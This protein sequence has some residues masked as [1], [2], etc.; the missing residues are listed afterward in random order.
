MS[1]LEQT[2]LNIAETLGEDA[3]SLDT[4]APQWLQ[5]MQEGVLVSLHIGRWRG[6]TRLTWADLG[7]QLDETDDK[8]LQKII[9]LGH[10][11]LLPAGVLRELDSIESAARKWLEKK[12]FR[13]YWGFFMPAAAY[14]DWK[15]GNEEYIQRYMAARDGIVQ[16]YEQI[17]QDVLYGYKM[18]AGG[19]YRRLQALHPEHLRRFANQDEFAAAFVAG[20]QQHLV[21]ATVIRDSFYFDVELRYIPLPSLLAEDWAEK[22]RVEAAAEKQRLE[23]WAERELIQDQLKAEQAKLDVEVQLARSE[24][25]WKEQLMREM[26]RDVIDQARRQKKKLVDGF[27]NDVVV[28]LRGMVYDASI[29]VLGAIERNNNLPPRS[30]VQL[31]NM[32]DQIKSLNF[33]GDAEIEQMIA[34]VVAQLDK[35]APDRDI[36]AI[37]DN[38]KDVATVVKASLIGL[39][40]RPR[41]ARELGIADDPAGEIVRRARS[42]LGLAETI[43]PGLPARAARGLYD[44]NP[45]D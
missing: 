21:S 26:H 12:S 42:S 10:K 35:D 33:Y 2:R 22:Q 38:L 5:L 18:A 9:D 6:K 24:A 34:P 27:L 30:V 32:V 29:D 15:A 20:V 44:Q 16:D 41:R 7:I 36:A 37:K 13:T 1:Q 31:K 43:Q 3:G 45:D 4:A 8:E 17:I 14:P 28:Q 23:A 11:K 39:G 25:D 19:A 40:Q